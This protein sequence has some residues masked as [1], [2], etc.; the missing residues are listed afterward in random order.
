MARQSGAPPA[1]KI[2]RSQQ[3]NDD[4]VARFVSVAR[5]HP[6]VQT[7]ATYVRSGRGGWS[8]DAQR[9]G[10]ALCDLRPSVNTVLNLN[11]STSQRCRLLAWFCPHHDIHQPHPRHLLRELHVSEYLPLGF[12]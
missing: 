3:K 1:N 10:V 4:T 11:A 8:A 5:S 12:G 6:G 7:T 9:G 2:Q